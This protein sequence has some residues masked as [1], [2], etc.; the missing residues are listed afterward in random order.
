[1]RDDPQTGTVR[2][3]GGRNETPLH[4]EAGSRAPYFQRLRSWRFM[5]SAVDTSLAWH[6]CLNGGAATSQ[7]SC[8]PH[9][10]STRGRAL[11]LSDGRDRRPGGGG[12]AGGS[13]GESGRWAGNGWET[14]DDLG[15]ADIIHELFT[16]ARGEPAERR[17]GG[18]PDIAI[19]QDPHEPPV[20]DLTGRW[21]MRWSSI[22]RLA[23]RRDAPRAALR[24]PPE[25]S[26]LTSP[27]GWPP[28]CAPPS[29]RTPSARRSR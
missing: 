25:P 27:R 26:A 7:P 22:I 8:R 18:L 13:R 15:D 19:R 29:R 5:T 1:M 28:A 10:N 9:G 21:R 17:G 20:I 14:L 6:G 11:A 23:R 16:L 24:L 3:Q 2:N 4:S 12:L